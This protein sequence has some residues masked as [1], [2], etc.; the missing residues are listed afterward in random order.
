MKSLN[1]WEKQF[2]KL[3][4]NYEN[5]ISDLHQE[6]EEALIHIK[7]T[8]I[9]PTMLRAIKE[10]VYDAH[11]YEGEYGYQRR[12]T[13]GGLGDPDNIKMAFNPTKSNR[14]VEVLIRNRTQGNRNYKGSVYDWDESYTFEIDRIIVEGVGYSWTNSRFYQQTIPRDFYEATKKEVE[15][16]LHEKILNYLK[17]QGW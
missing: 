3:Y 9:T 15:G 2:L 12:Y 4:S 14:E 8:D 6:V 11:T 17:Q 7:I 5:L 16:Y 10:V 1:R 13:S